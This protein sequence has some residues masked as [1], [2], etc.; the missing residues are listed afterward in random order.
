MTP[1]DTPERAC[2]RCGELWPVTRDFFYVSDR[3]PGRL[4]SWCRACQLES[5]QSPKPPVPVPDVFRVQLGG[6]L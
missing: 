4:H 2:A 3:G 5:K 1:D 6:A